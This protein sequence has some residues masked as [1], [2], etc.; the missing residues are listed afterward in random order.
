V[1]ENDSKPPLTPQYRQNKERRMGPDVFTQ[2]LTWVSVIGWLTILVAAIFLFLSQPEMSTGFLRYRNI[3]I[4]E[5][6]LQN[7]VQWAYPFCAVASLA[8]LTGLLLHT[9]RGRRKTDSPGFTLYLLAVLSILAMVL[10]TSLML[11]V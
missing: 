4:R 9:Q 10:V 6:W 1:A 5:T 2:V 11:K 3:S 7:W 8:S